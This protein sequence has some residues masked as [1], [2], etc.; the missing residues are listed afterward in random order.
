MLVISVCFAACK[1]KD[2]D[3]DNTESTT[4]TKAPEG[5]EQYDTQYE[6][7]TDEDGNAILV[8]S[9]DDGLLHEVDEN[10]KKTGRTFKPKDSDN[11]GSNSTQGNKDDNNSGGGGTP[12][13]QKGPNDITN[14]TEDVKE[15]TGSNLT[16]L[17]SKEDKVPKT[18]D[19]GTPVQFSDKDIATLT[20][21]LE[22]P[23]LYVSSFENSQRLP[24][25]VATHVANWLYC[26]ND[27]SK[28]VNSSGVILSLF[29][30]FAQSV[31]EFKSRCNGIENTVVTYDSSS[32]E[33]TIKECENKNYYKITATVEE[34]NNSGCNYDEVVAVVQKNMLN[35]AR[36][37]SIKALKWN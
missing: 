19:K 23:N 9:G 30:Y 27:T 36:G 8:V 31:V 26:R 10:G 2:K 12:P 25:D 32:D 17:P 14:K 37:F 21:M 15:T 35:M 13:A 34:V 6:L 3:K 20:N 29:N 33:F 16:T 24:I 28:I 1:G 18:T 22:V 5:L 4:T 11:S 7:T